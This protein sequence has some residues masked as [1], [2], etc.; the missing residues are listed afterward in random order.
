[1]TKIHGNTKPFEWE[2]NSNGCFILKSHRLN[3]DG[4]GV[5]MRYGKHAHVHR[6]VY[7]ECFGEIPKGMV[8]MHICDTPSCINPGHLKVGTQKD[9]IH[10]AMQKGR[11]KYPNEKYRAK[12]TQ[13]KNSKL[14]E[15]QVIEIRK[16]KRSQSQIAKEY[17]LSR[18]YVARVRNKKVWGWLA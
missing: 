1:M 15:T 7:Q 3:K 4:Y 6:L 9:N 11:A 12:G 14:T 2:T 18:G 10:D 8:V 16:D 17:G 13:V 5:T